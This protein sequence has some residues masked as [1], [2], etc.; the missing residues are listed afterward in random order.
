MNCVTQVVTSCHLY[1]KSLIGFSCRFIPF[2]SLSISLLRFSERRMLSIKVSIFIIHL[3][4]THI[5]HAFIL[6]YSITDK[7]SFEEVCR[8]RELIIEVKKNSSRNNS[9]ANSRR[10]SA[11]T[12]TSMTQ[13]PVKTEARHSRD[14]ENENSSESSSPSFDPPPI[15]IVANKSDLNDQREVSKEIVDCEC[16]D[17]DVA[18]V[19]CSAKDNDNVIRIF[20]QLM[21]Q[22]HLKGIL[23]GLSS[24]TSPGLTVGHNLVIEPKRE[25]RRSSLPVNELFHHHFQKLSH[26]SPTSPDSKRTSCTVS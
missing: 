4:V 2:S 12:A 5:G 23:K 9:A 3:L 11:V 19:E 15:V 16:I 26:K 24:S 18:F 14:E 21:L 17:W 1:T 13:V 8:L 25:R 10:G 22:A 6:V 20:H 7:E